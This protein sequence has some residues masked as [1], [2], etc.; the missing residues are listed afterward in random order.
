MSSLSGCQ[1]VG[2]GWSSLG[3]TTNLQTGDQFPWRKLQVCIVDS[4]ESHPSLALSPSIVHSLQAP[5]LNVQEF[6]KLELTKTTTG[7]SQRD[8]S[9]P[10]FHLTDIFNV[11]AVN[12]D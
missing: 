6:P 10:H 8:R 5:L 12:T 9:Y 4:I 11:H 3:I 1:T 7:M 2:G